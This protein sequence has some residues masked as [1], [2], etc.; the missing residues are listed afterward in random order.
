MTGMENGAQAPSMN[1]LLCWTPQSD[2]IFTEGQTKVRLSVLT[3]EL[4]L[5]LITI[6]GKNNTF[7]KQFQS[8]SFFF[9]FI[10]HRLRLHCQW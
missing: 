6:G 5:H 9:F 8:F 3:S 1:R 10:E 2:Y 4:N 7:W